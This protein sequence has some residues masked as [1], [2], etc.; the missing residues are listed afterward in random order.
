M[1]DDEVHIFVQLKSVRYQVKMADQQCKKLNRVGSSRNHR[2]HEA[3]DIEG[4]IADM[5]TE[6][7][8]KRGSKE[9]KISST[10]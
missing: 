1:Y 8:R 4:S 2:L 6:K 10:S 9:M 7:R 5:N 3:F